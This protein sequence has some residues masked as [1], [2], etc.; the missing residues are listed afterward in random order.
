MVQIQQKSHSNLDSIFCCG[1]SLAIK[2]LIP[3]YAKD[4]ALL[5][6]TVL[7]IIPLSQHQYVIQSYRLVGAVM[8][9]SVNY[10]YLVF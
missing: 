7:I 8:L 3:F 4:V 2:I 10:I 9:K 1:Y 5:K 6:F